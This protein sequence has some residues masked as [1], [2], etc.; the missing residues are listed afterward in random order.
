MRRSRVQSRVTRPS[1]RS[2]PQTTDRR[3]GD[4]D[5]QYGPFHLIDHLFVVVVLCVEV[6]TATANSGFLY[7]LLKI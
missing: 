5:A 3:Y 7:P 6:K 2:H 1:D 4:D